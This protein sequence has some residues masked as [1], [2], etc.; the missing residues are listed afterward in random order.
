MD[1]FDARIVLDFY[2]KSR[3]D[4]EYVFEIYDNDALFADAINTLVPDF[5]YPDWSHLTLIEAREKIND[6]NK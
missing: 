2:V 5:E 4:Y 1:K 6:S 3:I